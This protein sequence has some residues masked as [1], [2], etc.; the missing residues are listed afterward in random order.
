MLSGGIR[1]ALSASRP[2]GA[3][4]VLSD[5]S[6]VKERVYSHV[7]LAIVCLLVNLV[8]DSVASSLGTGREGS[9][10]VFCDVLVGLLTR[11][12]AGTLN[13]LSDIVG[14]VPVE[15]MLIDSQG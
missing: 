13:S 14:C 12:R 5:N 4:K 9:V 6:Q 10:G 1:S 3:Y 15:K 2:H 7:R 11:S 8:T